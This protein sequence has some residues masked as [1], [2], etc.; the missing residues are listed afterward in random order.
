MDLLLAPLRRWLRHVELELGRSQNTVKAYNKDIT[1]LLEFVNSRGCQHLSDVG[2]MELR[3][4]LAAQ[5][6]AGLSSTTVARRATAAR[7][8]FA[9]ALSAQVI[10][11]D[12]AAALVI[13]K[14]VKHLPNVLGQGQAQELMEIMAIRADDDSPVHI[15]D[16]AILE[17]LYASGIRVGELVGLDLGDIETHRRTLRVVGKGNK[18]RTVPYGA[19][20]Q[21]ALD[22][23][24]T[25]ARPTLV[26]PKSGNA[27]FLGARGGRLDQR[28]VRTML[29]SV[30]RS[31]GD[32]PDIS[33]HGLRHSAATHLI[34]GG[35]DIR[36]VQELLGHASLGTTQVYTHVSMERLKSVYQQAHPRA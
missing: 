21:T 10:D 18:Q 19:L 7:M 4:W 30:L 26:G 13:P 31:V 32:V 9:W 8:F 23:Y 36:A 29:A 3:G 27:L 33:P 16:R 11:H 12:P 14:V 2:I 25:Q 35:A 1:S 22:Q 28:S 20:A 34:E 5:R 15:R 6:T 24:L 17:L